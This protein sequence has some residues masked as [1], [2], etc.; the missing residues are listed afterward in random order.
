MKQLSFSKR[1]TSGLQSTSANLSIATKKFLVAV[2]AKVIIIALFVFCLNSSTMAAAGQIISKA[3]EEV[4]W[5]AVKLYDSEDYSKALTQFQNLL[6]Q[7]K[8]NYELNYY[9]GMCYH[10]LHKPKIAETYFLVAADDNM[11]R[12]K[13]RMF[14]RNS[15]DLYSYNI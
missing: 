11:L 4:Y 6:E 3:Q 5:K 13:I 10:N 8:E 14:T 15:I 2:Y 12:L 7:N 9:A 1:T